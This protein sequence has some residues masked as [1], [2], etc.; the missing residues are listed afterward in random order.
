MSLLTKH[1]SIHPS[2]HM[3]RLSY[4]IFA[5]A[6]RSMFP[7]RGTEA[8]SGRVKLQ[9]RSESV[10]SRRRVET[11][12][13]RRPTELLPDRRHLLLLPPQESRQDDQ[14][15]L[16]N[17]RPI[18]SSSLSSSSS[19][20]TSSMTWSSPSNRRR[21]SVSSCGRRHRVYIFTR[22]RQLGIHGRRCEA[23]SIWV[24]V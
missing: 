7:R 10:A 18:P 6:V 22:R 4:R 8:S 9:Q 1:P 11:H 21:G 24:P 2:I 13:R 5:S 17:A 12:R 15:C 3:F 20:S 16:A 23:A 19:L 14:D